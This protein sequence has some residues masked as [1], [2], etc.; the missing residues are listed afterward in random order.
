M[1]SYLLHMR[2]AWK[3]IPRKILFWRNWGHKTL[4]LFSWCFYRKHSELLH[5]FTLR[6]CFDKLKFHP[7]WQTWQGSTPCA[8]EFYSTVCILLPPIHWLKSS[9]YVHCLAPLSS[10]ALGKVQAYPAHINFISFQYTFQSGI[11]GTWN[12]CLLIFQNMSNNPP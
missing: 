5:K 3:Y 10:A 9:D 11:T 8:A 1:H 12:S 6:L 2:W 7:C 4:I